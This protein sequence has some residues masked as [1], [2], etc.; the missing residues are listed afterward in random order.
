MLKKL[1]TGLIL[2]LLIETACVKAPVSGK[3]EIYSTL[4]SFSAKIEDNLYHSLRIYINSDL[5]KKIT[6]NILL[7]TN[8]LVANVFYDGQKLIIVDYRSRIAYI[9]NKKPFN[10]KRVTGFNIP[11]EAFAKFYNNCFLKKECNYKKAGDFKFIVN[12][13][14]EITVLGKQGNV[15][16]KPLSGIVKGG[17]KVLKEVIPEGFKVIYENR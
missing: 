5:E 15:L 10:L 11:V 6:M 7:P 3:S 17:V 13:K 16:L 4:F 8:K 2:L 12:G 14:S 9:D 1:K